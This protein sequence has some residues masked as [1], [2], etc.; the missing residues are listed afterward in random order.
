MSTYVITINNIYFEIHKSINDP[1]ILKTMY[2][3]L[4]FQNKIQK[5]TLE[6]QYSNNLYSFIFSK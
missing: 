1:S 2:I 3:L 5:N 4:Y 6:N